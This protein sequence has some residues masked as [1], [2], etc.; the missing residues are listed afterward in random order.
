MN[1]AMTSVLP[2]KTKRMID[3][4]AGGVEDR[5]QALAPMCSMEACEAAC[6]PGAVLYVTEF[7]V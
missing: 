7:R 5:Q 6:G 3:T 2:M 4:H 1:A